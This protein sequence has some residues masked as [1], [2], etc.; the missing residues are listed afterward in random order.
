L[1]EAVASVRKLVGTL[2]AQTADGEVEGASDTPIKGME[3]FMDR[4]PIVGLSN[5]MAPPVELTPDFAARVVRGRV[6]FTAQY[7]GAPGVVHGGYVAAAL[8][9]ALGMATIFSGE[10]GMTGELTVRY[11]RPTLLGVPLVLEASFLRSEGRRIYC[12]GEVR[13]GD[14]VTA[15]CDGL[16]IRVNRSKFEE[17]QRAKKG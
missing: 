15:E 3:D 12:T 7:E 5:P 11:R 17:L 14:T 10:P 6:T 8:D 9:E 2:G 1:H 16:F 13:D 4:S